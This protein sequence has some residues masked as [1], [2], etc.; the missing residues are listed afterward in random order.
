MRKVA[1]FIAAVVLLLGWAAGARAQRGIPRGLPIPAVIVLHKPGPDEQI[2][3]R[4]TIRLGIKNK[5][6]TFVLKD[7]YLNSTDLIWNDVWKSI[8]MSRPNMQLQG[9]NDDRVAS[10]RPGQ[11]V[12]V[13][14]RYAPITRTLE[15]TNVEEGSGPTA[16][17]KRY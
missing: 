8:E 4:Q 9:P 13:T 3:G 15:I 5:T 1:G 2:G 17:P 6:Y 10:I 7:A 14:G 16:P 11:T 12:A